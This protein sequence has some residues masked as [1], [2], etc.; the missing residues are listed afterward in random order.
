V[1]RDQIPSR[2]GD[3]LLLRLDHALGQAWEHLEPIRPVPPIVVQRVFDGPATQPEA[4]A[5]TARE[6]LGELIAKCDERQHGVRRLTLELS[7][8]DTTPERVTVT[9]SRAT[10]NT[11][12][13]WSLLVPRLE[14]ANLGYGV[15]EVTLAAPRTS[16]IRY[17]QARK[18]N[19]AGG[20]D[21]AAAAQA[22]SELIDTLSNRLG[23]ERV[24]RI[25]PVASHVP[26]RVAE[27][28]PAGIERPPLFPASPASLVSHAGDA[29]TCA[30]RPS[31]LLDPPEPVRVIAVSPDGPIAV[32]HWRDEDHAVMTT[33]GPERVSPEW[34]R[35]RESG[36]TP[37]TRD[38]FKVQDERGVWLWLYRD[39]IEPNWFVHGVWA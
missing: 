37:P 1:P 5:I 7:R 3:A 15:D 34:W 25:V 36:A 9:L 38:Y 17:E 14:R 28:Y 11:K 30:D 18:W 6:L 31:V 13:L 23:A 26:E 16:K 29:V 22:V 24:W 12:H 21:S 39:L 32:V 20:G 10:R 2:F 27:A 33:V 19:D 8:V 35:V 4:I